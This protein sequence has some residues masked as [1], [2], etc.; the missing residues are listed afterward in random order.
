MKFKLNIADFITL[1][2]A[3]SGIIA[4][5][6]AIEGK[7]VYASV[8][9]VLAMFFDFIDG[10][11][12]RKLTLVTDFGKVLD[13]LADIISFG[14]APV[15][16]AFSLNSSYLAILAYSIFLCSGI[17]RLSRDNVKT[18]KDYEGIPIP[19]S[20]MIILI[21]FLT[22]SPGRM[23]PISLFMFSIGMLSSKVIKKI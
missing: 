5:F 22:K 14:V 7:L 16:F 17:L 6:L 10:R 19:F 20:N 15:V 23:Y 12:S 1:S 9:L 11:V 18:I 13:N 8:F 2:N 4:I 3:V 21:L